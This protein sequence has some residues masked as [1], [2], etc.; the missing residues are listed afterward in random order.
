MII[1]QDR[2]DHWLLKGFEGGVNLL[3]D[4]A[5]SGKPNTHCRV[6]LMDT[7]K[8]L[9][10]LCVVSD[11]KWNEDTYLFHLV[12]LLAQKFE[13]RA[14]LPDFKETKELKKLL[15]R[16]KKIDSKLFGEN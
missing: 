12:H 1:S 10:N 3:E 16:L 15:V 4:R 6:L 7:I 8:T 9:E 13:D 2:I 5:R 11:R 14:G